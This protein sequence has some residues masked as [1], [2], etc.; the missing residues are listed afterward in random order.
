MHLPFYVLLLLLVILVH[1]L[2]LEKH[3]VTYLSLFSHRCN[4][5]PNIYPTKFLWGLNSYLSMTCTPIHAALFTI[6]KT[7]K[8]KCPLWHWIC[9]YDIGWIDKED[10]VHMCTMEYYSAIE[11]NEIIPSVATWMQPDYYTKWSQSSYEKD[12]HHMKSLIHGIWNMAQINLS[13][14]QK[15]VHRLTKQTLRLP[16]ENRLGKDRVG[17]WD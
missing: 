10:M 5:N 8:P 1:G 17:V 16:R 2:H 9:H 14:K 3:S 12:K 6:A 11:Q 13:T 15:Q 4:R 7:W